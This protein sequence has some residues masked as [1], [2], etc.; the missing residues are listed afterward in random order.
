[1]TLVLAWILAFSAGV[2]SEV[3]M[4]KLNAALGSVA[5]G[6]TP[7]ARLTGAYAD[8]NGLDGWTHVTLEGGRVKVKRTRPRKPDAAYEGALR[9]EEARSLARLAL[10]GKLWTVASTR[11]HGVPD[12]TRPT[13]T[14]G[15]EGEGALSV[16]LW[17][18]EAD[19]VP[20]FRA[21]RQALLAIAARVSGGAVT[22]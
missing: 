17:D 3:E 20:A 19:D 1:M 15:V 18:N 6:R 11:E 5:E 16:T 7:A 13:I 9:E 8:G 22:Y 4:E 10:E 21:V 14:L 12:E 2:G